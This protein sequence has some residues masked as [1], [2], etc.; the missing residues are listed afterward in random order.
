MSFDQS[1]LDNNEDPQ[2]KKSA[3]SS[4]LNQ[5]RISHGFHSKPSAAGRCPTPIVSNHSV[6]KSNET[7]HARESR[8]VFSSVNSAISTTPQGGQNG[9]H[10]QPQ[11]NGSASNPIKLSESQSG[12]LKKNATSQTT[13][14]TSDALSESN[15]GIAQNNATSKPTS[16]TSHTKAPSTPF[17]DLGEQHIAFP[18]QFGSISPGFQ[19]PRTCSAPPNMIEQKFNQTQ[20][21]LFKSVPS[22]SVLPV[23][24]QPLQKNDSS[25]R[26]QPNS[27]KSNPDPETKREMQV[28]SGSPLNQIQKPSHVSF[29][30]HRASISLPDSNS[31]SS[32]VHQIANSPNVKEVQVHGVISASSA[33]KHVAIQLPH[34]VGFHVSHD[35][36]SQDHTSRPYSEVSETVQ[37]SKSNAAKRGGTPTSN[38]VSGA[39]CSVDIS[40]PICCSK[41]ESPLQIEQSMHELVGTKNVWRRKLPGS[42]DD[43]EQ[44]KPPSFMKS[45]AINNGYSNSETLGKLDETVNFH[46]EVDS[47]Q[48]NNVLSN[49]TTH[50]YKISLILAPSCGS[51]NN[52]N[53]E[54]G[55]ADLLSAPVPTSELSDMKH[56]GNRIEHAG[57][58]CDPKHKPVVDTNKMRNTSS[59]GKKKRKE[60][61]QKA[62]AAGTTSD[63]YMA[64]KEPEQ[65]KE[66]VMSAE[67]SNGGLNMKH[68]SAASIKEEAVL[69]KQSKFEPDDWEDAVDISSGNYEGFEDKA[70]G[71]VALHHED[72]SGDMA[73]KY[74]R[75]FLLNFAEQF[76]D[77][78][79][80]FE[81]TPSMKTLMSINGC[82][83]S[84]NSNSYANLGKMDRPSGGSRLDHRAI[85]VDASGRNSNLESAYLADSGSRPTQ[86]AIGGALKN[87]RAHIGSQGKIQRNGSSTDRW[88]RDTNFQMKGLISPPTPL[89]MMHRAEKKYEVGK[90]ADEEETKQR[91]LKA[92]LNKLT[93][94]NFAK[95]FEQVKAVNIDSAKTLTGVISQ[96]FDKAL[97]EPT[98]CEMYANFC[99]HLAGDLPDFSDDNQ[100]INFK[101]LLLNKC[102]EEF[103]REQEE[104]DNV[105]KV[106]ETKQSEEEQEAKRT[107]ARRRMLGNIRLIGELYK[108]KMITEKIMHVCIKKLLG[109]YQNP[110]EEDIEALCKLMSTIGEMIDHSKAKQHMDAYFEMM[111]ELSN[112]MKLSS[113]VRFML[114]D[115][116]DL[117]KNKWQQRRKIEGP[118]KIDEVHR[119]AVQERQAQTSRLGRGPGTNA[120][121]RRGTSMDFGFRA[122]ALLPSPNAQIGG[123]SSQDTRFEGKQ[124]SSEARAFPTPL[125]QRPISDDAITLGPQGSLARGMSIRGPRS[126][127][128]SS[129]PDV[130]LPA[131]GNSQRITAHGSVSEHATSNSRGGIT[132]RNNMSKGFAGSVSP[133]QASTQEPGT[134]NGCTQSGNID[135]SLGRS[136][137]ISPTK[138]E[139]PALTRN[140]HSEVMSEERLR[141]KSVAAIREYYSARDEKEVT[142]CIKELNSPGFYSSMISLW[143][144]DSFERETKERDLLAKLLVSLAK[145]KNATFTQLQLVKGIEYVLATLEDAVNDA[146]KAPE[147]MGRLLANLIWED[148][149]PLKEIG[150]LI[151]EGGEEPGSLVQVGVAADVLG[152]VLEAVQLEKGQIF[153]NQILK[154]SNLQLETFLPSYP[155]KLK[156]TKLEKFI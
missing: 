3:R 74:S 145:S 25:V 155:I 151:Y 47:T 54:V 84:V 30:S 65:K 1:R 87:T 95:L 11:L 83:R 100:K 147:F 152:N 89:Q 63:L 86:G 21:H 28:S 140:G 77:L 130:S 118:K 49:S 154:S 46:A 57:L 101:R 55:R 20:S 81:I 121:L 115:A 139:Q 92:I 91:Q 23:P 17:K 44:S 6:K 41:L 94:Q 42:V 12:I 60:I 110:D 14:K 10:V 29:I 124:Q 34:Q 79:D 2:F 134:I 113:R 33:T 126:V 127:S 38:K 7:Q 62:D 35:L 76:M 27:G 72:G 32:L 5:Q 144:T 80:G 4:S 125:H 24:K 90:V 99:L 149:I 135:S 111:T 18:L 138:R 37:A 142:L 56:E 136:Q 66:T 106:G 19:I 61:L 73:K 133:D 116:I 131:A 96:I 45:T 48:D 75:D 40:D 8:A 71:K 43:I 64:Y 53:T 102:Q 85:G 129:L 105:N 137:S 15:G 112:N 93:P 156:S 50:G 117:R 120:S 107:K 26:G 150:K 143:I 22:G 153:V 148:L 31:M 104:N 97:T 128:S 132:V 114:K 88:Q 108:K 36:A 82:S 109:Q 58:Q 70:K 13:S 98:F 67:S 59:R 69:T 141:E 51:N 123:S 16:K 78:P 119:D 9:S 146:P 122:S 103:E 52:Y 68:E 39:E